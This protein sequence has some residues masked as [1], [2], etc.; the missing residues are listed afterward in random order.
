MRLCVNRKVKGE[1]VGGWGIMLLSGRVSG[2]CKVLGFIL[3]N[4]DTFN[5]NTRKN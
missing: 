2:V 1:G 3:G 4:L 5:K